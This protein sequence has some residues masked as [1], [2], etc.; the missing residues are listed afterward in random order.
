M[1]IPFPEYAGDNLSICGGKRRELT[2]GPSFNAHL[3]DALVQEEVSAVGCG[4]DHINDF[5]AVLSESERGQSAGDD[6]R[7]VKRGPWLCYN[8]GSGFG[9]YCSYDEHRYYR[10]TRVWEIDANKGRLK[11]WKRIEYSGSRFEEVVLVEGGQITA[12]S[13]TLDTEKTCT[14]L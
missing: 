6:N 3:Y 2:E 1:H 13:T 14:I 10:R 5:C 11:T 12:P 4:H 9:G 8:G 7:S